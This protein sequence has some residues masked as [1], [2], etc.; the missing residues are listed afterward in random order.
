[1][2]RNKAVK[3]HLKNSIVLASG[4]KCKVSIQLGISSMCD[5][6]SVREEECLKCLMELTSHRYT[7]LASKPDYK[8]NIGK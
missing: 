7:Y 1:M 6:T 5:L 8:T 4:I 3:D 2:L